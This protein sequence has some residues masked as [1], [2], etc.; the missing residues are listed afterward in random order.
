[1]SVKVRI[2]GFGQATISNGKWKAH[3]VTK[4]V[5]VGFDMVRLQDEVGY[6]PHPDLSIAQ[7]AISELGGSIIKVT[8]APKSEPGVIY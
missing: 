5:L 6:T 8:N 3:P 4:A 7:M 2:K 1:M